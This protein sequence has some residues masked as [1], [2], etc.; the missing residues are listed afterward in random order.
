[1]R[2]GRGWCGARRAQ[3]AYALPSFL[4]IGAYPTYDA[5]AAQLFALVEPVAHAP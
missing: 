3:H 2:G 4:P 5:A 1:M